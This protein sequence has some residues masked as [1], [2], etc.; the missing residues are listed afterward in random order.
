MQQGVVCG[1]LLGLFAVLL[2][3]EVFERSMRAT[4][5]SPLVP[6][7]RLRRPNSNAKIPVVHDI[8]IAVIWSN[9]HPSSVRT[10]TRTAPASLVM[11]HHQDNRRDFCRRQRRRQRSTSRLRDSDQPINFVYRIFDNFLL[12]ASIIGA[13]L[14]GKWIAAWG[15]GHAFGYSLNEQ[16]TIWSSRYRKLPPRLP[17]RWSRMKRSVRPVNGCSTIECSMSC[18]CLCSQH[19]SLV[20]C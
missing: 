18:L 15:V 6:S 4:P 10:F 17:R 9:C 19:Q 8:A 1:R 7:R 11:L 14:A 13:L 2:S 16:L 12:V 3:F 20:R 5:I